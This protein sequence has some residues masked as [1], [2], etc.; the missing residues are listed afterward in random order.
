[1]F[2]SDPAAG[3][4]VMVMSPAASTESH[5]DIGSGLGEGH[6]HDVSDFS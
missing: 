5:G 3:P 4:K 6:E 2:S 1:M